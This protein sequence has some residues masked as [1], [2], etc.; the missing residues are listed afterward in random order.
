MSYYNYTFAPIKQLSNN[1]SL[2][3]FMSCLYIF[4]IKLMNGVLCSIRKLYKELS[5]VSTPRITIDKF[6]WM[7]LLP[8][9]LYLYVIL[10]SFKFVFLMCHFLKNLCYYSFHCNSTGF[11]TY[12]V[13]NGI[14]GD[15]IPKRI[16]IEISTRLLFESL[17]AVLRSH[18]NFFIIRFHI[19]L[20][21]Q[22]KLLYIRHVYYFYFVL[23]YACILYICMLSFYSLGVYVANFFKTTP[24]YCSYN[25]LILISF[26]YEYFNTLQPTFDPYGC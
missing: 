2:E 20:H 13:I 5:R 10:Y 12:F 9:Y 18:V 24:A 1:V 23:K 15:V 4:L 8:R 3:Y 14:V 25:M 21:K 16:T 6:I 19:Q 17:N 11:L 22:T 26:F 7:I